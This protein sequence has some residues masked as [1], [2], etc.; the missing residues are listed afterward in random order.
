VRI[1]DRDNNRISNDLSLEP[2][3]RIHVP[4]SF[5]YYFLKYFPLAVSSA[6]AIYYMVLVIE[7]F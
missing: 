7:R 5:S 6:T 4:Y 1:A 3:T 2:E